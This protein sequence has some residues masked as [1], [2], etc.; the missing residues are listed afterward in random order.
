MSTKKTPAEKPTAEKSA[1]EERYVKYGL[2]VGANREQASQP[3]A[4]CAALYNNRYD[5]AAAGSDKGAW[6]GRFVVREVIVGP[7]VVGQDVC[8]GCGRE[9]RED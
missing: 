3:S 6:P 9:K 7:I 8:P 2:F 5:A 4:K 1:T